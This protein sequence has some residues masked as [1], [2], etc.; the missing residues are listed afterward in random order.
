MI[1]ARFSERSQAVAKVLG[2]SSDEGALTVTRPFAAWVA[3]KQIGDRGGTRAFQCV[4]R[5][6]S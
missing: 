1:Q 2:N 3:A 6:V 5:A 4:P